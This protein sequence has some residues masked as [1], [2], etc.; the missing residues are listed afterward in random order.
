LE[1]G[2]LKAVLPEGSMPLPPRRWLRSGCFSIGTDQVD[3]KAA[4]RL[5]IPVFS[6]PFSNTRSVAEMV[7]AE[8]VMLMRGIPE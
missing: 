8:I 7:P 1:N 5:G 4:M 2:A 3:L 6:A